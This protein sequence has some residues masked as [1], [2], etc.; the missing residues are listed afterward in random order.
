MLTLNW[1]S[2][3]KDLPMLKLLTMQVTA[4]IPLLEESSKENTLTANTLTTKTTKHPCKN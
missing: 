2:L 1:L 3:E 4:S